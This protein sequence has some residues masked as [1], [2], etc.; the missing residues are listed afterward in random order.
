M[1][2]FQTPEE[3]TGRIG[4]WASP[5]FAAAVLLIFLLALPVFSPASGA[6]LKEKLAQKQSELNAAYAEYSTFQ[7][8]LNVLAEKHNAAE[9]RMAQIDD[10]INGVENEVALAKKDLDITQAQLAERLVRLYKDSYSSAPSYLEV[11]FEESDFSSILERFSLLGR[12]ADRDQELFDQVASY[13]AKSQEREAALGEKKQAQAAQAAELQALQAEMG[14][15]FAAASDE[16]KRLKSQVVSLREQVREA[17]EA[18]A[19]AAAAAK[20]A[21]EAAKANTARSN[22][23]GGKVQAGVF[24]FPVAGPHSFIDSWG[25]AR[26]GGRSHKGT[27]ILAGRGTPVVA[28]VSG[29]IARTTPTDT[30]LGGIT[31][32]LKGNNGSSYYYAHL[33]GIA[34]GIHRG[35]PVGAG[36]VIGWV[37]STGNAGSCNHLH[38]QIHPGGGGATNPYATLR[39]AD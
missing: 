29:T 39:A 3:R 21:A 22:S 13:L 23:G 15:K 37:G 18:A 14:D 24:V 34:G 32:W 28:C 9:V 33:D 8:E 16:Y 7:D 27:D 19:R 38:F 11:L 26:S 1:S 17:E 4:R 30:G 5:L 25:A 20:A 31:I 10:A 6:T 35:V 12:V 36:Q 2:L